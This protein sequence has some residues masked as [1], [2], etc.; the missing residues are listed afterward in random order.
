[1]VLAVI[2]VFVA[3]AL[4]Y[5]NRKK[6]LFRR[7]AKEQAAF[8]LAIEISRKDIT[9]IK[10]LASGQFGTVSLAEARD[11]A[12]DLPGLTLVAVK[13]CN[14]AQSV[15][16][17]LAEGQTMKRLGAPHSHRNVVRMLGMCTERNPTL[18]ILELCEKG[19]L[20]QLLRKS[21]DKLPYTRLVQ[22]SR[23]IACGMDFLARAMQFVHRDLASR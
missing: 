12:A 23:D 11:V 16:D 1:M 19:D 2:I 5:R 7:T 20:L 10:T 22:F 15:Q 21:R 8:D 13:Q 17:F 4:L 14:D 9:I 18:L 3:A 6:L